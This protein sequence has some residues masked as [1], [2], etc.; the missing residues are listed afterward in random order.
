MQDKLEKIKKEALD[1]L[2]DI[3]KLN[4]LEALEKEYLGRKGQLTAILR[5]LSS[6][7]D[8]D[9]KKIGKL[10]NEI[11][12]ELSEKFKEAKDII[13]GS[14]R[15]GNYV[16]VSIPGQK[17]KQG[18]IHPITQV[19]GDL[20]KLFSSMGFMVL[21]GPE[22]ESDHYNFTAL[23]IP[24]DHP[25]RDM[26]DTFYIDTKNKNNEH[27]MVMRTHTSPVQVRAM[28]KYGA[29]IKCVVPGRVFRNEAT[30]ATHDTTFYQIE[31]LMVG[32][33]ISLANLKAVL[34]DVLNGIFQE[35]V[36]MRIRPG[37]FPFVEPGLEIDI[38][39]T[40]C[41]GA[42]CPACK[43][44][45]WLEMLGSGMIHPEVLK[46][47]GVDPEKYS[48]FAFGIGVTRLAM[49]KYKIDDIRLFNSGDLRFME[50]F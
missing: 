19:M 6:M 47:G 5:N 49:M 44:T 20:E 2:A 22:L 12:V 28:Q 1:K 50:Q 13:I 37:Y 35:E 36:G 42:K 34:Q 14:A 23:N 38:A 39:C 10:S 25:A 32:E 16:D 7:S 24:A 48:G 45:G 27:D 8:E 29:P 26:Q 9:K 30:D 3:K 21:D 4:L 41:K 46:Y 15:G 31:G 33:G 18:H 40:I 17:I 43:H 11:K